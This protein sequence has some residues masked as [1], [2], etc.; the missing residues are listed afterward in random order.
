[1]SNNQVEKPLRNVVV[2]PVLSG[3]QHSVFPT[4][5]YFTEVIQSQNSIMHF[6]GQIISFW[7]YTEPTNIDVYAVDLE[8]FQC[9]EITESAGILEKTLAAIKVLHFRNRS[10][11][12]EQLKD[13]GRIIWLMEEYSHR[14]DHYC[15]NSECS[16]NIP[17][18]F[19]DVFELCGRCGTKLKVKE[20]MPPRFQKK[21]NF[22]RANC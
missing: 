2:K 16:S 8:N 18:R 3:S 14:M 9:G 11:R 7:G 10:D 12:E 6:V 22:T 21:K 4:D 19:A 17:L 5:S 20:Y 1:M 13:F 15:P